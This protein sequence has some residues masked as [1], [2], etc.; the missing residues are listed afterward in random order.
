[1]RLAVDTN[2]LVRYLTADDPLQFKA[3]KTALEGDHV[4]VLSL[5]VLC[6]LAWVLRGPPYEQSGSEIQSALTG[7]LN[8]KNVE[9]DWLAADAGLQMLAR[10]GDFADGVIEHDAVR[11]KCDRLATFDRRFVRRAGS[12][13]ATELA[14]PSS[15][16]SSGP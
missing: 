5:V 10:G 12:P 11:A 7:L 6:E 2:V 1:V 13:L 15:Q 4:I 3:A 8:T 9:T 16:E 14:A